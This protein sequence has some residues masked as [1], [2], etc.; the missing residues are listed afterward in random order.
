MRPAP[1]T[2]RYDLDGL[3]GLAIGLVVLFHIFVGRVSGGVDVFLFL[4]GFF[5]LGAQ[6][7]NAINP[8]QSINPLW[9]L[10]RTIRRL[11]PA[12]VVVLAASTLATILWFPTLRN[13]DN[14]SQVQASLL[15]FQNYE[16]ADQLATYRAAD[17]STS[18]LQHLW[19][20]SVQGQFYLLVIVAITALA[21]LLRSSTMLEGSYSPQQA[22]QVDATGGRLRRITLVLV[23]FAT[24]ASAL[25]ATR[26]H[27]VDQRWNYYSFET[28]F[29]E[30]GL[31]ALL[32]LVLGAGVLAMPPLLAKLSAALGLVL[33]VST[34]FLFDGAAQF[35]GPWTLWPIGGAALIV[36]AGPNA[37]ITSALLSSR[38]MRQLGQIAYSLY[39]WHWPLLIFATNARNQHT[40][41]VKVG[42]TVLV[43]SVVLAWLTYRFVEKPLSQ[44]SRR[45]TRTQPVFSEFRAALSRSRAKR[46]QVAAGVLCTVVAAALIVTP[47]IQRERIGNAL[48]EILDPE[49]YPGAMAVSDGISAPA[50]PPKPDVEFLADIWPRPGTDGCMTTNQE[51]ADYFPEF[52]RW[53][54]PEE[55]CVY[56]N[57][58]AERTIVMVGGSH[59]EQ[60]YAPI[61][62]YAQFNDYRIEVLMRQGCPA[63]LQPISGVGE[64]CV[65][66]SEHALREIEEMNPDLVLLNS[67]RPGF[68]SD[69]PFPG[70]YTPE[71]FIEF[72]NALEEREIEFAAIRDTPWPVDENLGQF[73]PVYCA[74]QGTCEIRRNLVLSPQNPA[75]EI[76]AG[77]RWGHSLDFSNIF[78][79]E[80]RCH[81]VLGNLYVYRDN[82]HIT[83]HFAR[84]LTPT[85]DW[86]LKHVLSLP[87]RES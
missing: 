87:H 14:A 22:R 68:Q 69:P 71:G 62:A 63:T 15:Y 25:W 43:A 77:Y 55:P 85:F 52:R 6:Y 48:T 57:P 7:R 1:T 30:M 26:T 27:M 49:L 28:R 59:I 37:G 29:W 65:E 31:G 20:M 73:S 86:Q 39:L 21:W 80:Q 44:S 83:E 61:E 79:D 9:S 13:Y 81:T 11:Y 64:V 41:S 16:L 34:G 47:L 70:D 24:L 18:P 8:R 32:A 58:D 46:V 78:C 66:W 2:Y 35:P 56:G 45:P 40:P 38:P 33:V 53:R 54:E 50:L 51:P 72:F 67:T 60:W 19:S 84:T 10:W 5:F 42:L 23:G 4:S 74:P 76:L 82:N 12:L 17:R 3:R 75:E 36:L